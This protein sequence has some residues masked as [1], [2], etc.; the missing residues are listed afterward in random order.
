MV[1]SRAISPGHLPSTFEG[2]EITGFVGLNLSRE[3]SV[4]AVVVSVSPL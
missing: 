2:E 4:R 1:R 3:E